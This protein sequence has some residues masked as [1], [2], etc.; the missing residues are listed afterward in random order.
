L[1][2]FCTFFVGGRREE[3]VVG[4]GGGGPGF[5]DLVVAGD[6]GAE[7]ALEGL[8]VAMEKDEGVVGVV[9]ETAGEDFGGRD[10]FGRVGGWGGEGMG[11]GEGG[12]VGGW[13]GGGVGGEIVV[14]GGGFNGFEV[15]EVDF[16]VLDADELPVEV[17]DALDEEVLE[18]G[19]GAEVGAELGGEGVVGGFALAVEDGAVGTQAVF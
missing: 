14:G 8:L 13:G 4:V 2:F 17:D 7:L 12:K 1:F 3:L 6:E 18:G 9:G 11:R 5:L 15:V 19:A 16:G 10:G